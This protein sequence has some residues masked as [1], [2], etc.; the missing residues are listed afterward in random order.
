[1]S[2]LELTLKGAAHVYE[3][4][5]IN[6]D[7][8]IPARYLNVHEEAELARHAMEDIDKDF[9]ERVRPGDF[10]FAGDN[11][12]CGSSR[13]HAVWALRGA[14]IKAVIARSYAR[15]FFRNAINNGFLAIECPQAVDAVQNGDDIEL[16]LANGLMRNLTRGSEARFVPLSDFARELIEDGGLLPHIQKKAAQTS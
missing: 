7:E 3:R 11:F 5:H 6:T 14:G 10:V 15:I 4:A 8:I 1:M 2:Q 12:G 13:E 16:D 9:I